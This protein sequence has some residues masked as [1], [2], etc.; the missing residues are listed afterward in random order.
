MKK[1]AEIDLPRNTR[2]ADKYSRVVEEIKAKIISGKYTGMLPGTKL[3]ADEYGVSLMTADKAVKVLE[4]E[5]L[6]VRLP[7][8]GTLI[9]PNGR[10]KP[11][12]LA[13]IVR[14]VS[15]PLT[16]RVVGEL[17]R[18]AREKGIQTL[19]FQH[20]DDTRKESA[21]ARELIA[22][23]QVDGIVMVLCSQGERGAAA[24]KLIKAGIPV[25]VL[26][27]T[28]S[29][30]WPENC[31]AISFDEHASFEAGT[32]Q[33]IKLGHKKIALVF[34]RHW[35]GLPLSV[36]Y[37][38]NPRWSGYAS[39]M[40]SAGLTAVPPIWFNS[41]KALDHQEVLQFI[42]SIK[43]YTALFLHHDTFAATVLA[44][45]H[46]AGVHVPNDVSLLSY[47]G[48]PLTEALDLATMVLPMEQVALRA[49]E[50]L[51]DCKKKRILRP[52]QEIFK[53]KIQIR[54]SVVPV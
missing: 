19:F 52:V 20:F 7:R 17:G 33:L 21:I 8:K 41:D 12:T 42:K 13:V 47:D 37:R 53:A 45:L 28:P 16:S 39:A 32:A 23:N 3:L 35:D 22:G 5:R 38:E 4:R 2:V 1:T 48:A 15:F 27:L 11:E 50:I 14:D 10:E 43:P 25:V 51:A 36:E 18:M 49:A 6:V 31:H 9:N 29:S 46:R 24:K 40:Q 34:P 26:D 54:G 44:T 30:G